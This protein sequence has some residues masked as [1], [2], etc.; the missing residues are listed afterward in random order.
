MEV[1]E[2]TLLFYKAIEEFKK[3]AE[4]QNQKNQQTESSNLQKK[5]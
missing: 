4:G 2:V 3:D 1:M 5:K